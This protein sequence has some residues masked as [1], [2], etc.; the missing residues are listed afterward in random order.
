MLPRYVISTCVSAPRQGV[1]TGVKARGRDDT[2]ARWVDMLRSSGTHKIVKLTALEDSTYQ[3]PWGCP[4]PAMWRLVGVL[5]LSN[6]R[7]EPLDDVGVR[8]PWCFYLERGV[9]VT[10][11]AAECLTVLNQASLCPSPVR[12][13]IFGGASEA[14]G[15][16]S[17]ARRVHAGSILWTRR[18]RHGCH[19]M[20]LFISSHLGSDS[21][22][23]LSPTCWSPL[24]PSLQRPPRHGPRGS[25]LDDRVPIR[26][27]RRQRCWRALDRTACD[28]AFTL[29][30]TFRI[31]SFCSARTAEA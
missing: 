4:E 28:L 5:W 24:P 25:T 13:I 7:P 27:G 6:R 31:G 23:A 18:D 2:V 8:R 14:R 21:R 29:A 15:A 9:E 30:A 3:T 11:M 10:R 1:G 17:T 20:S 12:A 22:L 16:T 26:A 19:T